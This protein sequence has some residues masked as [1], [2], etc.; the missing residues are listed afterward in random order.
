[1]TAFDLAGKLHGDIQK[2]FIRAEVIQ[3]QDLIGYENY[4]AA[5]VDGR[6]RTEGKEY[7]L[8][9]GDVVLIKWR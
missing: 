2:G 3:S 7:V 1:M 8:T 5:K 6:I 4:S 9:N